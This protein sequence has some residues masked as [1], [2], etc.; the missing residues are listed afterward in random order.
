MIRQLLHVFV[1]FD[2]VNVSIIMYCLHSGSGDVNW[3]IY[4]FGWSFLVLPYTLPNHDF[5]WV[6]YLEPMKQL[7]DI[8]HI[9]QSQDLLDSFL[10][11]FLTPSNLH[12]LALVKDPLQ[13]VL[14][15]P[16]SPKML[17]SKVAMCMY[18]I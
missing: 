1:W 16:A 15:T 7:I 13:Q 2:A 6:E 11:L 12:T 17:R 8:M 5:G 18:S 14:P 9:I 10:L 3:A 4:T